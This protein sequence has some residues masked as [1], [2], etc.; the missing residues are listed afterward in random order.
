MNSIQ[1]FPNQKIFDRVLN[2]HNIIGKNYNYQGYE[3]LYFLFNLNKIFSNSPYGEIIDRTNNTKYPFKIN[4]RLPWKTPVK[5]I[6]LETACEN[7]IKQISLLN[8]EQYYVYWSGGIDSTLMLVVFLKL[9][10][11][12]KITVILGNRSIEENPEFYNN[13]LDGK[14]KLLPISGNIPTDGIHITGDP[15]DTIWAIL[16]HSFMEDESGKYFYKPYEDWFRYRGADDNF[17]EKTLK[18]MNTSG[19]EIKTLFEARWWFYLNCKSQSKS[20]SIITRFKVGQNFCPFYESEDFDAWSYYNTDR[21]IIGNDWSTYKYTAKEIIYKFDK[22]L[23]YYKNKSKEYS[24]E[25]M[26]LTEMSPSYYRTMPLFITD[27]YRKPFLSSGFFFSDDIYKKE[28]Y[29]TYK[30]LFMPT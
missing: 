10:D 4:V 27:D 8:P 1:A 19:R 29:E 17:L 11:H 15:A 13:F 21:M 6:D 3:D 2:C 20:T 7:K 16:D 9:I 28:L 30:D 26:K 14:I 24:N 22:N 23:D 18:F 12:N 5:E 25:P